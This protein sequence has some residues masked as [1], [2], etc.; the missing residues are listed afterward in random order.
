MPAL[1]SS[2]REHLWFVAALLA[3][4]LAWAVFGTAAVVA[5]VYTVSHPFRGY[6]WTGGFLMTLALV[7]FCGW[8]V[9]VRPDLSDPS[10]RQRQRTA[11]HV[12][13][14]FILLLLVGG[15]VTGVMTAVV[16][17]FVPPG[18]VE[19]AAQQTR[20]FHT[21]PAPTPAP[22]TACNADP[23]TGTLLLVQLALLCVAAVAMWLS[24]T[25]AQQREANGGLDVDDENSA[26]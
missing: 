18:C 25:V 6:E 13:V 4:L 20:G 26:F 5:S 8:P 2:A 21:T 9:L 7:G 11:V 14:G 22:S 19:R 3:L 17:W 10:E 23:V 16:E 12:R 15:G 24:S 1:T